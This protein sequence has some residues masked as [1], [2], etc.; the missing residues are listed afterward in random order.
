MIYSPIQQSAAVS[1]SSVPAGRLYFEIH[2]IENVSLTH[3]VLGIELEELSLLR[4]FKSIFL[5]LVFGESAFFKVF[6]DLRSDNLCEH[7]LSGYWRLRSS[8]GAI[9][10]IW[11]QFES[12]QVRH[13]ELRDHGLYGQKFS[14]GDLESG[15][16]CA[17]AFVVSS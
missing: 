2:Y 13:H 3:I 10:H 4:G 16:P 6:P 1:S 11:F 5:Q 9:G 7:T 14:A 17:P 12:L 15:G 8:R